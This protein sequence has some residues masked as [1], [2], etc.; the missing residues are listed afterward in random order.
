V[1]TTLLERLVAEDELELVPRQTEYE[2]A[3]E[4][5]V[6]ETVT[7]AVEDPS[8]AETP[9]GAE[10]G[11][12]ITDVRYAEATAIVARIVRALSA[13]LLLPTTTPEEAK[14]FNGVEK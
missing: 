11:M 14:V 7:F 9:V 6:H 3:P 2:V 13:V 1:V 8:V 4:E 5:A 10:G 12:A